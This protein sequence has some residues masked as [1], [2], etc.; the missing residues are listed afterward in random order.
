MPPAQLVRLTKSLA[1]LGSK[2]AVFRAIAECW[3]VHLAADAAKAMQERKKAESSL[4]PG[5]KV[6][7]FGL[8][9]E[10][11]SRLNDKTGTIINFIVEKGRYEVRMAL[12]FSSTESI[13]LNPKNLRK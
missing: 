4:S 2:D 1:A 8:T 11:G 7:V 12:G 13:S 3:Q 6:E 9:S 10:S 5:D